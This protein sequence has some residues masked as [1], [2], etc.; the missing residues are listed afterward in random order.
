MEPYQ[1]GGIM[2]EVQANAALTILESNESTVTTCLKTLVASK[3]DF[4]ALAIQGVI[5]L[6]HNSLVRLEAAG[7]NFAVAFNAALPVGVFCSYC[8]SLSL[9]YHVV[10]LPGERRCSKKCD[11]NGDG[12]CRCCLFHLNPSQYPK[13]KCL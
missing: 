13:R 1:A 7:L 8:T 6:I 3:A 12:E 9:M 10:R 5:P 2:T 11:H 4:E